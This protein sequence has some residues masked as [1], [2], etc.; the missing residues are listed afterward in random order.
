LLFGGGIS[1]AVAMEKAGLIEK[2][3]TWMAGFSG[4]NEFVLILVIAAVSIFLSEMVS[5]IAQVIVLA[6]VVGGIADALHVNPLLLGI[7]MTFAASCASMMP[8]GT[9]PN[10]IVFAS[11]NVKIHQMMRVGII[12]NVISVI[13]ITLYCYFLL[14]TLM[15]LK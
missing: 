1:L 12:M 7:P 5:N 14:P 2:L 10:A 3:G 4:T 15:N 9:P 11:G 8:M 13:L 6:P